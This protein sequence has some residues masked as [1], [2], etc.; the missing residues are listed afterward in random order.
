MQWSEIITEAVEPLMSMAETF[1][2]LA[3]LVEDEVIDTYAI[4]GAVAAYNYIE[5]AVTDDL[6]VLITVAKTGDSGL[7]TLTPIF[8]ALRSM[9][10][11]EFRAEGIVIGEWP[12]Q[13][14]PVASALDAEALRT[15]ESIDIEIRGQSFKTRI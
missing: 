1:T 14:L 7:L 9:G 8:S 12:V 3:K 5:A 2:V 10:Y 15:A 13:F 4:A 6:D 11:T